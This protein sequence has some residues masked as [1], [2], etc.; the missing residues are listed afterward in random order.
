MRLAEAY[1]KYKK[2]KKD[3]V[4]NKDKSGITAKLSKLKKFRLNRMGFT[5]AEYV[6]YDLAH[7]DPRDYISMQERW[8][9]EPL[10]G[11]YARML[12]RKLQFERSFSPYVHV[13]RVFG[14]IIDGRLIDMDRPERDLDPVETLQR[15]G[16]LIVKPTQSA[17]SGVGVRKI[18]YRA[19][20]IFLNDT[21]I[22][23]QDL[24][25]L[26]LSLN[27]YM[28]VKYIEP[29]EYSRAVYPETGNTIRIVTGM[30]KDRRAVD[31]LFAVHRF[32]CAESRPVD[33]M[34]QGGLFA[35]IDEETGICGKANSLHHLEMAFS[36]HP[37]TNVPIEGLQIPTWQELTEQL[38][39][40]HLKMPFYELLAW[41][42][43]IAPDETPWIIEIN[44]GTDL[45]FQVRRPMR[46]DKLG[47]F[48][49]E[50][51]LLDRR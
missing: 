40:V 27:D 39:A 15:E 20:K 12:G 35:P 17:G 16:A 47:R 41:D 22:A 2:W 34:N 31:I 33:S 46:H 1:R 48:M 32:G 44:R 5:E 13:P 49:A 9:L 19:G 18:E 29:H 37:D 6:I 26:L 45:S 28:L 4:Q 11:K 23:E 8:R 30:R 51:G 43:I 21:E 25:G 36:R 38:K 10:N 3:V 42:V 50:R 7:N 14:W 24:N